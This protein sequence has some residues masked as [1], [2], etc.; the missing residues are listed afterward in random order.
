MDAN[1]IR[2]K[3]VG[4]V[5]R[6]VPDKPSPKIELLRCRV[7]LSSS[8]SDKFDVPTRSELF[9]LG[10]CVIRFE[11]D[12][13]FWRCLRWFVWLRRE[14]AK[15]R[16]SNV[17][18]SLPNRFRRVPETR[19]RRNALRH[20]QTDKLRCLTPR[21]IS[22]SIEKV[23][24]LVDD[25]PIRRAG[26]NSKTIRANLPMNLY[27]CRRRAISAISADNFLSVSLLP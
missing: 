24:Q 8:L 15:S 1:P 7:I 9:R 20:F 25:A 23:L 14:L 27:Q 18:I 10:R 13:G 16:L 19:R 22:A 26:R 2:L 17:A 12:C 5:F 21:P 3:S 6:R 11:Q 4:K